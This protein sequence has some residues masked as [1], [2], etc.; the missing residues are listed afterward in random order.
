MRLQDALVLCSSAYPDFVEAVRFHRAFEE[1]QVKSLQPGQE[2]QA[3]VGF[4]DFKFETLQALYESED[5]KK[6]R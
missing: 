3:F 1:A 6:I 2:G 4:G 5:P